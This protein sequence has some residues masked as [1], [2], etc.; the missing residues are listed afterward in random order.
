MER[1][2][3]SHNTPIARK[4]LFIQTN[5]ATCLFPISLLHESIPHRQGF[6]NAE[7]GIPARIAELMGA[8][9][10][11][12]L[13]Q[14]ETNPRIRNDH[15]EN[16]RPCQSL[17]VDVN[18]TAISRFGETECTNAVIELHDGG[19]RVNGRSDSRNWILVR[20]VRVFDPVDQLGRVI[21]AS[22]HQ[23]Q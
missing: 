22:Q 9:V 16:R 7:T 15:Y 5:S 10:A 18:V 6:A 20:F 12:K 21:H 13:I 14:T 3:L 1:F 11:M 4:A 2:Q 23:S 8:T 19:S 17:R